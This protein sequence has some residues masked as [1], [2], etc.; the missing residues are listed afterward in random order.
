MSQLLAPDEPEWALLK[1]IAAGEAGGGQLSDAAENLTRDRLNADRLLS[2]AMRHQM[3]PALTDFLRVRGRLGLLPAAVNAYLLHTRRATLHRTSVL[4][5]EAA[6]V[7]AEFRRSSI[8]VACTKGVIFQAVLYDGL[9]TRFMGD[10]DFMILPD[11]REE[12]GQLLEAL[13]YSPRVVWDPQRERFVDLPRQHLAVYALYPDHLPHFHRPIDDPVVSFHRVDVAFSLTWHGSQWQVPMEEVIDEI[14]DV[15]VPGA[16]DLGTLPSL[17]DVHSFLF[18]VLHLF[19]EAW[20]EST[21]DVKDLKL[22]HFGDVVRFWHRLGSS[23]RAEIGRRIAQHGVQEPVAW[24]C[25]HTDVLFGTAITAELGLVD[26]ARGDLLCSASGKGGVPLRWHGD[27]NARLLTPG[28]PALK[29][30]TPEGTGT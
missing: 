13:G 4:S 26:V 18:A 23:Q 5:A 30:V 25:H 11:R 14:K 15:A 2:L 3:L 29:P 6:R 28:P 8:E 1:A 27:M 9:G 17:G 10:I 7:V 22:P 20:F 12:A 24:V 19:R 16:G 21:I